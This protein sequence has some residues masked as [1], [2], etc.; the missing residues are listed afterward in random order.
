MTQDISDSFIKNIIRDYYPSL[1]VVILNTGILPFA[2]FWI[3][4]FERHYKRSYRE[5]SIFVKSYV[6][7]IINTFVI[8]T[9]GGFTI[10]GIIKSFYFKKL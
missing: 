4:I 6:F 3:A 1:I 10:T 2:M 7:L 5:K 8:P 9:F